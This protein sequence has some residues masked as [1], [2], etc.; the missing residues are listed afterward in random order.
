MPVHDAPSAQ[1]EHGP[2]QT[3]KP[4]SDGHDDGSF[5]RAEENG[6]KSVKYTFALSPF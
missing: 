4:A 5:T 6:E 3:S 1:G 2:P